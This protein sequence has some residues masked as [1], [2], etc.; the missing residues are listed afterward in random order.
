MQNFSKTHT[1]F[2]CLF[3]VCF[4]FTMAA[5][6]H[7]STPTSACKIVNIVQLVKIFPDSTDIGRQALHAQFSN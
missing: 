4:F 5:L 7:H 2:L 3:V 6:G 1:T